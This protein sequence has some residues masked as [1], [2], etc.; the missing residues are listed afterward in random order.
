MYKKYSSYLKYF[1]VSLFC[2]SYVFG[3]FLRENIAGGAEKDFE[4]FTWP[5]IKAF[6]YNFYNTLLNYGTFGEG[7]L[8]LF[9]I[10]N[11]YF[12]PFSNNKFLF[13]ASIALISILNSYIFSIIIKDKY[14]LKKVDSYLYSSIFLIL[15]FFRSSAF[16]GLTEN[17]GWLFLLLSIKYFNY[18]LKKKFQ[19]ETICVFLICFFS[20]LALYTRPYLIFF[21]I[22]IVLRSVFFRDY[23]IL[24]K[25]IF[26]YFLM[27]IPGFF[28][29]YIW[30][31]S[32]ALGPDKV[33]LF[34]NYH[35]PKFIFKNLIIFFSIF[36]FYF[37]PF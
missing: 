37:L 30:G 11:A 7:S 20:S 32:V 33:D 29:L 19:N 6:K 18:Y 14:Q 16:W 1:V 36:F 24:K 2:V 25:S 28:L 8:P 10:I 23:N 34:D 13:Q 12:N 17:F 5:L 21:P 27:S 26:F 22:F 31:G 3:F 35:N 4:N 15:P 9:H